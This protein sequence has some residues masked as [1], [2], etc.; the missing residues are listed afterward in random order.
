M[1]WINF[2]GLITLFFSL[3]YF[4]SDFTFVIKMTDNIIRID[5]RKL[6]EI[7]I[8]KFR[9]YEAIEYSNKRFFILLSLILLSLIL[10]FYDNIIFLLFK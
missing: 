10:I 8:R 5:N 1:T 9:R 7:S 2:V 6:D 4:I 3:Y